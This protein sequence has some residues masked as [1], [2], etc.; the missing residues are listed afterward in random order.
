[1]DAR[2]TSLLSPA[3]RDLLLGSAGALAFAMPTAAARADSSNLFALGVASG[4]PRPNG[5]VL[6]TRLMVEPSLGPVRVRWEVAADEA[7]RT[8][9]ANGT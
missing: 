3:R 2:S 1:M 8:V 9:V 6:W 4:Q 7:F 5:I